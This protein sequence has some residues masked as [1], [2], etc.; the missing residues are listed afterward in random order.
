MLL[1]DAIRGYWLEKQIDLSTATIRDYTTTFDRFTAFLGG[2]LFAEITANDVRRFLVFI[3]KE[4]R[5][6]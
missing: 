2:P 6:K 4:Y 3:Q 5:L 1:S